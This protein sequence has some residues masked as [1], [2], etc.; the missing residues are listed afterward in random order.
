MSLESVAAARHK[1]GVSLS[2]VVL[3]LVALCVAAI[4]LAYTKHQSRQLFIELQALSAQR[5]DLNVEWGRLQLEQSSY[6]AHSLI[7]KKAAES[8][9]LFRPSA[10]EVFL[11]SNDGDYRFVGLEPMSEELARLIEQRAEDAAVAAA[12]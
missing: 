8:L 1:P 5:D 2:L 12:Q 9:S 3:L 11:I 7:E 4:A 10:S 6:A